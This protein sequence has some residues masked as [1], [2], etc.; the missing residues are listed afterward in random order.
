VLCIGVDVTQE[1]DLKKRLTIAATYDALTGLLNRNA[2]AQL[3]DSKIESR[4]PFAL[5]LLDLDSFKQ[6]ND[7]R[8][9]PAG[10][11]LLIAIAGRLR[12]MLEPG[13]RVARLGGDEFALLLNL[14]EDA[15]ESQLLARA[16]AFLHGVAAPVNLG[17]EVTVS[18]SAG[19]VVSREANATSEA[20]MKYV[21]MSM[22]RAKALGRNRVVTYSQ[23][24]SDEESKRFEFA[25]ALRALIHADGLDVHYQPVFDSLT[26]E[27]VAAEA[28]AR[29]SHHGEAI[30]PS[31]FIPLAEASGLIHELW[32]C[33][34]RKACR[35]A[36]QL[37]DGATAACPISVNV[38]PLQLTDSKFDE[39]TAA[40]L[41]ETSC[42]PQWVCFEVTESAGLGNAVAGETLRKLAASGV[43]LTVDD[44][45]T[46]Y[47][48][49]AHLKRLPLT[50]LKIDKVFVRDIGAGDT[51]IVNSIIA[52][53]HSLGLKVVAEGVE[54]MEELTELKEM[55]CDFYQ[56][57]ISSAP[58]P[59]DEFA[60]IL[61][62][63]RRAR[64]FR[65]V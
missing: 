22:Y 15:T 48:N 47:S 13:E 31:S 20:L 55:R 32:V 53:A 7:Y 63:D 24:I 50:T 10:D 25:E 54:F 39:Q 43:R 60:E 12:A 41:R 19:L 28:L 23:S 40:I 56:G 51:T 3:V 57:F 44:F 8:G 30:E 58:I 61:R 29:W 62:M 59:S 21:D 27:I 11:R 65:S 49:F 45:G 34:M 36:A 52:M 18:A 5:M 42:L 26:D 17:S 38:S 35:F 14:P 4:V 6:V 9:H 64:A 37:N 2:F 16:D 33:V 1:L 46:G